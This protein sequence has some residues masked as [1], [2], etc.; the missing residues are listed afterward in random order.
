MASAV[1]AGLTLGW[2]I[3]RDALSKPKV[4]TSVA[5]SVIAPNDQTVIALRAVNHGPGPARLEMVHGRHKPGRWFRLP[6][7]KFFVVMYDYTNPLSGKL[8]A[9]LEVGER[10][11]LLFSWNAD[12]FV[13]EPITDLGIGDSY[14]RSHWVPQT[15]LQKLQSQYREEFPDQPPDEQGQA[16][17]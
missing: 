11:T 9:R 6:W 8:P 1:I 3:Y 7:D 14:G 4:R 10:V 13:R 2:T 5:L 15:D 17:G 16:A 12:C